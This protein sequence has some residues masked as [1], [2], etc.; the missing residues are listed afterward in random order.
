MGG[1]SQSALAKWHLL[2]VVAVPG[3]KDV[4]FLPYCASWHFCIVSAKNVHQGLAIKIASALWGSKFGWGADW[5]VVVDDD[6]DPSNIQQ[7][8]WSVVTRCDP[9]RGVHIVPRRRC[10]HLVPRIPVLDRTVKQMPDSSIIID[11]QFPFE[12]IKSDPDSIPEVADWNSWEP[13]ARERALGI[14]SRVL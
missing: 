2:D 10:N 4:F 13:A 11:A 1:I 8:L 12:W 9:V 14:L 5:V 7:V 3:V 6:I